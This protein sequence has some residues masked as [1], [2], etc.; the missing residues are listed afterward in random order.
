LIR[1][2]GGVT[3]I[4]HLSD[5]HL[6]PLPSFSPFDLLS[7]RGLGAINY[8]RRRRKWHDMA[9]LDQIVADIVEEEPDAVACTGDLTNLA[10]EKEFVPAAVF[11]G[12][13]GEPE[14]VAAI[15]GNHDAY[16]STAASA[17]ARVWG[18]NMSS[19]DGRVGFPFV[20]RHGK[21]ALIGLSSAV[22]TWPLAATGEVG[23]IQRDAVGP[24]LKG[25]KEEGFF[26]MLLV[27]HPLAE[28]DT[29]WMRRLRDAALL[30]EIVAR[31]GAE[32]VLHGHNHEPARQAIAGPDG[33]VPV[34]GVPSCSAGPLSH[35]PL[36]AYNLYDVEGEPGEWR[37]EVTTRGLTPEGQIA[38]TDR[39][40]LG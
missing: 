37:C 1:Y 28:D 4:A 10:L 12:R 34:I 39:Y 20:R 2:N 7:K 16:V 13:L 3:V 38:E 35:E 8:F 14:R 18:A 29:P 6:G 31:E 5:P 9:V 22:P 21:V 11:L 27:H 32:L 30:R 15:P 25:L 17:P 40:M 33:P 26:R 23:A 36:A 24:M 19:D